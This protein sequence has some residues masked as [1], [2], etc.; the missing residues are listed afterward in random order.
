MSTGRVTVARYRKV[1]T[2]EELERALEMVLNK[3]IDPSYPFNKK[4]LEDR[5][6]RI[7]KLMQKADGYG[8]IDL[9]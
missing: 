1:F 5:I 7:R 6:K 9:S 8:I 4:L 2:L 3:Y